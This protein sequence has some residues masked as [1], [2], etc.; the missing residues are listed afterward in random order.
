MTGYLVI[1][2][3][4]SSMARVLTTLTALQALALNP[5]EP[6]S[7]ALQQQADRALGASES[8]ADLPVV[9][10]CRL[11]SRIGRSS[12]SKAAKAIRSMMPKVS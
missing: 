3:I 4:S 9:N 8:L 6:M 10:P 2:T 12:S 1:E 11:N 7:D 5:L